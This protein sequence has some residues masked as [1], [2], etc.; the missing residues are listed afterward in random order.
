MPFS[1][2]DFKLQELSVALLSGTEFHSQDR[3]L[4]FRGKNSHRQTRTHK[5]MRGHPEIASSIRKQQRSINSCRQAAASNTLQAVK[6]NGDEGK[7]QGRT[8]SNKPY[9]T[10]PATTGGYDQH[11]V[12]VAAVHLSSDCFFFFFFFFVLNRGK[13]IFC[14]HL[15]LDKLYARIF[16]SH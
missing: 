13:H 9:L 7:S 14:Q 6:G 12:K 8:P 15:V 4:L 5:C 2:D 10:L 3:P 1:F 16:T 11:E